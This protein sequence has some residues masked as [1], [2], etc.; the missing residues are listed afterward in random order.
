MKNATLC[1]LLR[2]GSPREI[3]LGVKKRGFGVGKLN[4]LGGKILPGEAPR[5]ATVREIAEES[6]VVVRPETLRP[7]GTITF[8][9]PYE[10]SFD[11]HVHVFTATEWNGTPRE[12]AEMAPA[13][14]RIDRIPYDRMWADDPHWLPRVLAGKQIDGVFTF[15][16]DN[17]TLSHWS[18]DERT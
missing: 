1:F 11:H 7:A 14:F 16:E 10:S 2:R 15:A 13:W 8:H 9:F 3:L 12:T 6:H 18:V 4:G 5:A 17:E